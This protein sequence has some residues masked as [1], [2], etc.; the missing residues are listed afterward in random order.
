MPP[1]MVTEG[2]P[3]RSILLF[4]GGMLLAACGTATAPQEGTTD[5]ELFALVQQA[6]YTFYQGD[7]SRKASQ[8]GPHGHFVLKFNSIAAQALG[9]DGKLPAGGTFPEG[10]LITKETYSDATGPLNLYAVMLKKSGDAR[11]SGGWLWAEYGETGTVTV[12]TSGKGTNCLTC[13]SL[14]GQ[15]DYVRIFALYP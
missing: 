3:L 4:L 13:H 11:A 5:S 2:N 12:S 7:S 14:S 8:G 6:T 10:S 1:K 15:R 9:S